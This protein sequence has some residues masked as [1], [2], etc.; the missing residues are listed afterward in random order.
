ML[1]N[2]LVAISSHSVQLYCT[3]AETYATTPLH[4]N[5]RVTLVEH[6][7]RSESIPCEYVEAPVVVTAIT[8]K[9]VSSKNNDNLVKVVGSNITVLADKSA[10]AAVETKIVKKRASFCVDIIQEAVVV[11]QQVLLTQVHNH[12]TPYI[13]FSRDCRCV[14]YK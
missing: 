8:S 11:H 14:D 6:A 9:A 3:P 10:K 1:I 13:K 2:S 5:I 12:T 4:Y 7:V